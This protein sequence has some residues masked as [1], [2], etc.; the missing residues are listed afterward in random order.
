MLVNLC[1]RFKVDY[2]CIGKHKKGERK[3]RYSLYIY[4]SFCRVTDPL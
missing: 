1:H 2:L 3:T 4:L